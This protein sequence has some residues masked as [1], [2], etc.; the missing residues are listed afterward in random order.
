MCPTVLRKRTACVTM[1]AA[2]SSTMLIHSLSKLSYC[3]AYIKFFT[4]LA[5]HLAHQVRGVD[6]AISV[7]SLTACAAHSFTLTFRG[8]SPLFLHLYA[9]AVIVLTY[10]LV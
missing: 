7:F 6:L 1:R 10:L 2:Q 9:V 4:R 8:R 5:N 3:F